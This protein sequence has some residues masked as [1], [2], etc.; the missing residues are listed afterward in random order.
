MLS[1][2]SIFIIS[3]QSNTP[4]PPSYKIKKTHISHYPKS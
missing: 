2:F 3:P 1:V 4:L